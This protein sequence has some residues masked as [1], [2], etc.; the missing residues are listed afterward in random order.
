MFFSGDIENANG[1][2]Y[3]LVD[4]TLSV[5]DQGKQFTLDC[6]QCQSVISKCLGPFDEWEGRLYVAKATGYNLIHFTPIQALGTSNSAYSI[7]DQLKLNPAYNR[8]GQNYDFFHVEG[9]IKKMNKEWEVL[10]LTDLVYNHSA[11]NSPWLEEHPECGYNMQNSPHL[12]PAYFLDRVLAHFSLEVA[13]G[14]WK[15][16]GIPPVIDE[17]AIIQVIHS[18]FFCLL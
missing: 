6:L 13:E 16:Q 11:D 8:D 12:K 7:K 5:G 18:C 3:F 15:S 1:Q 4:P 14:K 9:L 10:S 17:E 2:G